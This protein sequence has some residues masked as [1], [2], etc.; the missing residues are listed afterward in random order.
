[1]ED[2]KVCRQ[3]GELKPISNYRKYYGG[4]KGT[5]TICKQC[6]R[7]NSRAKYL[8]RKETVNAA[9][10]AELSKIH[11]LYEA[12]RALGLQPPRTETGGRESVT[13]TIDTMLATYKDKA[14]SAKVL[15]DEYAPGTTNVPSELMHW[16]ETPLHEDPDYYIDEVYEN[17][18]SKYRPA[19][20]IDPVTFI[21]V[22]DDTYRV[23]LDKILARFNEYEDKYYE[24]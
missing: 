10:I 4:R 18:K 13:A 15:A 9:E 20:S 8:E 2:F 3:C 11:A 17:L 12:Q 6:E 24:E 14:E 19:L 21:P 1:M 23:T 5:Y 22:Y 7:I 16:L